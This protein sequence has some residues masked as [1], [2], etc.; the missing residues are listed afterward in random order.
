MTPTQLQ[1]LYNQGVRRI[2][3]T[4]EAIAAL[5]N[6]MKANKFTERKT[7]DVPQGYSIPELGQVGELYNIKIFDD[8]ALEAAQASELA[9]QF[10]ST[11]SDRTR[12]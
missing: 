5:I 8:S 1:L 3:L 7:E 2:S 11:Q 10:T 12:H 4:P 6:S 9:A